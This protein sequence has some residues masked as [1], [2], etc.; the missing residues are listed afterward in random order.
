MSYLYISDNLFNMFKLLDNKWRNLIIDELQDHI[1][2][3]FNSKDITIEIFMKER[4]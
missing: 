4:S 3:N 1:G 2:K